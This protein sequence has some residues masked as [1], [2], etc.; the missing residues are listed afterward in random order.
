MWKRTACLLLLIS[1]VLLSVACGNSNSVSE[2]KIDQLTQEMEQ[3][4]SE[5]SSLLQDIERYKESEQL[6]E[7]ESLKWGS[8]SDRFT[9]LKHSYNA[10]HN[11]VKAHP[12]ILPYRMNEN[13]PLMK[14][15]FDAVPDMKKLSIPMKENQFPVLAYAQFETETT[16]YIEVVY[17]ETNNEGDEEYEDIRTGSNIQFYLSKQNGKWVLQK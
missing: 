16:A 11:V 6:F 3:L 14:A 9:M 8:L 1:V 5:K 13:D 4:K 12:E 17:I 10:L 2:K 15:I 7:A